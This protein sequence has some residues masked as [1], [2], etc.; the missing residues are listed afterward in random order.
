MKFIPN[1]KRAWRMLSGQAQAGAFALL[2][3]W[4]VMPQ[5]LKDP[6]PPTLVFWVSMGLLIFGI[7]GRLVEQPK[8]AP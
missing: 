1:W 6:L 5:D 8:V 7:F 2:G 3:A 4:Q